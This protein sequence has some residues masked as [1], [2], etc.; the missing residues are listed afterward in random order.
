MKNAHGIQGL[1]YIPHYLTQDEINILKENINNKY[2]FEPIS[3]TAYSRRVS[4]YGY[5]YSYNHSGLKSADA[6]PNELKELMTPERINK[7]TNEIVFTTAFNQ[8]II[9]EYKPKQKISAHTDHVKLFG[10]IVACLTLGSSVPIQFTFKDQTIFVPVDEGSLY[11]M[12]GESRYQ[13]KHQ[14]QNNTK[15]TRYSITYRH[16]NV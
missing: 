1:W 13:W 6:L 11:I 16:I 10:P 3:N 9:N 12:T 5:F 15:E 8:I 7:M 4:H 14:L 2:Q